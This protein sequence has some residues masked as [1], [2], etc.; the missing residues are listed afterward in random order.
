M[1]RINR[2]LEPINNCIYDAGPIVLK[3]NEWYELTLGRELSTD[4]VVAIGLVKGNRAYGWP[5]DIRLLQEKV[6]TN[7]L[8]FDGYTISY[9]V[10]EDKAAI[11][12]LFIK[13]K[14]GTVKK[15]VVTVIT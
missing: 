12:K 4:D 6:G 5:V 13:A 1:G 15:I 9:G 10:T 8:N 3:D 7:Q 2:D 11:D 14:A